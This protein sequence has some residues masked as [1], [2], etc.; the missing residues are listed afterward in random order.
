MSRYV[1]PRVPGATVFFTVDLEER[2]SDLLLR[3][4]GHLRDAV[5]TT[6]AERP[7]HIDA[8]VVLP[9]HLHC[10]WTLPPGDSDFSTRWSVIKARFSRAMPQGARR[11]SHVRRRERGIWQRR[12]W[13]HHIR[14]PDDLHAHVHYCW[15]DPVKHG[16]AAY[17]SAWAHSS[18]HRDNG[19]PG[20]GAQ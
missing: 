18:W 6:R 17:P 16:L 12:F 9:D 11:A 7:F 3:E 13:E 10:I 5:R 1:R 19:V 8:W 20:R 2:G 4:I 15:H 14:C